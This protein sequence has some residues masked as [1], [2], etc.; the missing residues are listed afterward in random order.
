MD[1]DDIMIKS[2]YEPHFQH[3]YY[4][5]KKQKKKKTY[6]K[7]TYPIFP[8]YNPFQFPNSQF[9]IYRSPNPNPLILQ[10][11]YCKIVVTRQSPTKTYI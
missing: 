11:S 4:K 1:R 5:Q 6:R 7:K 9:L 10:G 8:L 2:K 3:G